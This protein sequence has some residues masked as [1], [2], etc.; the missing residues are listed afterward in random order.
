MKEVMIR[1]TGQ[2]VTKEAGED[3]MEFVTEA[4]I[5]S[6]GGALYLVYDESELSGI[7]GCR[8]RLK[9]K[10]GKLQLKRFGEDSGMGNELSFEKGKRTTAS[11]KRLSARWR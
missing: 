11:M 4:K 8:T 9:L 2:Q 6:R 1:I 5:Y 3:I 10:D 7:P